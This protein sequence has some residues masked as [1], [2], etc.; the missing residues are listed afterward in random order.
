MDKKIAALVDYFGN[1]GSLE[2]AILFT[3]A[4]VSGACDVVAHLY[5]VL[6]G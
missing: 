3:Q 4:V 6:L 5:K 2:D 1:N